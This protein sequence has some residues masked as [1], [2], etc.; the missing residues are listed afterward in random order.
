MASTEFTIA[1][2]KYSDEDLISYMKGFLKKNDQLPPYLTIANHFNV[3]PNGVTERLHRLEKEGIFQRNEVNK[4][5]FS[6]KN[7]A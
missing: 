4:I 3:S 7:K 5:M 2:Q 6:R 1:A